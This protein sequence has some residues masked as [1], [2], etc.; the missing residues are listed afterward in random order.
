MLG[1]SVGAALW[2]VAAASAHPL[3]NFTINLY[4]GIQ[5]VPGQIRLDYVV[6]MAEIPTAQEMASIDTNRDG[7]ASA[8]EKAAW[9]ARVAPALA[10]NLSLAVDGSPVDLSVDCTSMYF[11]AGQT[12]ETPIL[13][14]EGTF[15]ADVADSG[16]VSYSDGNYS[17]H[18]GWRE[19]SAVG[20]SGAA[21][22]SSDVPTRT[23]SD[24]LLSYPT[25][26]LQSPLRV[27][28][29]SF[30]YQ[31]SGPTPPLPTTCRR[32]GGSNV[33]VAVADTGFTALVDR[34]SPLLM[35]VA[36]LLALGFGAWHAALPGH[37]KTLMAA[38]MVGSEGKIRQAVAI[39]IA[40]ALMHTASVLSIG[41][42]F[43]AL[44]HTVRTDLLYPWLGVLSGLVAVG[45]G[46]TLL[47]TRLG[48]WAN[49]SGASRHGADH[50]HNGAEAE[51]IHGHRHGPGGLTHLVPDAPALSRKGLVTLAVAGGILPAPSAFLV[52]IAANSAHRL[53]FGLVLI[54]A[55]SAGLAAA[56]VLVGMFTL[57]ARDAVARR[58]SS[59]AG[60]LVP[61]LSACA[62]VG[63]GL[64]LTIRGAM[65]VRF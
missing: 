26:M 45:L 18:I 25:G 60:K 64:F 4:S 10:A 47:I 34:S 8:G 55:F 54:L 41:L 56:L 27:T 62:I 43:L 40:V 49:L 11:R 58:L 33:R 65:Q 44:E 2:P 7:V 57:R 21:L 52:L 35:A 16:S 51:H 50:D 37:G 59:S 32:S 19:I 14:F 12:A 39:G 42:V 24:A 38:Y 48:A 53:A 1:I 22:S 28:T 20:D 61:V 15:V 17:D 6:D 36:L 63:V 23:V 5:V 31:A 46:T 3:G 13:R 30:R 29:A 9:A